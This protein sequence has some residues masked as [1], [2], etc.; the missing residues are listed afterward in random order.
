MRRKLIAALLAAGC[1]M[2]RVA[3]HA[4][5]LSNVTAAAVLGIVVAELLWR[6]FPAPVNS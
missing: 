6:R 4:H 5:F 3:A 2:S 1:A